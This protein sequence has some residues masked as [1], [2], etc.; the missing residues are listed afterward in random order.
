VARREP[1]QDRGPIRPTVGCSRR[2]V[3]DLALARRHVLLV[4][5][6][7]EDAGQR[8]VVLRRDRVELVVVTAGTGF[9]EERFL[10]KHFL[11]DGQ[12]VDAR[13]FAFP[14]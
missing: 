1:D 4:V 13:L 14:K 12:F 9:Q 8:V 10:R 5:G 2:R 7:G 3:V 6:A 11:K